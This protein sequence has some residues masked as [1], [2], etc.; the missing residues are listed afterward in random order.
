[1]KIEVILNG[2]QAK[3]PPINVEQLEIELNYDTDDAN[4]QT[5]TLTNFEFINESATRLNNYLNAGTNGGVGIF[6][7]LPMQVRITD[8]NITQTLLD[9]YLDLTGATWD[10]DK[11][12]ADAVPKKQIDWLNE[13][14]DS[15]SFEYISQNEGLIVPSDYIFVPYVINTIPNYKDIVIAQIS[16]FLVVKELVFIGVQLSA[17]A[18]KSGTIIDSLGGIIGAVALAIY[19]ATIL[20]SLIALII[21][22]V[23]LLIQPVKYKPAMY[24]KDLMEKGC[25][26]FGLKFQSSILQ[27]PPFD[28]MVII[29][30]SYNNPATL[31]DEN[32]LGFTSPSITDQTGYYRGTFGEFIRQMKI[33]FNGKVI[34]DGDTLKFERR[35]FVNGNPKYQLPNY[36]FDAFTTNAA[37]VKS[38]FNFAFS[39]DIN[40]KNTIDEWEGTNIDVTLKPKLVNNQDYFLVK[41]LQ[42]ESSQ[43][44]LAK[45]KT[46]LTAVE[47]IVRGFLDVFG[48]VFNTILTL[49]NIIANII[50][51]ITS[52]IEK[53]ASLLSLVGIDFAPNIPDVPTIDKVD[54]GELIDDRIGMIKLEN[55]IISVPKIALIDKGV[56]D[57][58]TKLNSLNEQVLNAQYIYQNFYKQTD[59]SA[60]SEHGQYYIYDLEN[61]DFSFQ[62]YLDVKNN[63]LLLT[64]DGKIGEIVSLKWNPREGSANLRYKVNQLYNNNLESIEFLPKGR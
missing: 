3:I 37:D 9:G 8:G 36:D 12:I 50:N 13:V 31:E 64:A 57:R 23:Q 16:V 59:F 1:L 17:D 40:D 29:P 27:S 43:F 20:A 41:G 5:V 55:D 49:V 34:I 56:I 61:I 21:Q 45:R 30:E 14:A 42:Q 38:Q 51:A 63:P 62:N 15:K 2:Q 33:L 10:C 6:E 7:G 46:E 48:G 32:I 53:L 35:D 26:S 11:V 58:K 18:A 22:L 28:K 44:A 54:F 4:E 25:Q 24:A 60:T 52:V 39:Y 47:K 19:T